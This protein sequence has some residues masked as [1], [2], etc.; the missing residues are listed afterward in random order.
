MHYVAFALLKAR[1]A[2]HICN[3]LLD[4]S[5]DHVF[6]SPPF[7]GALR[8]WNMYEDLLESFQNPFGQFRRFQIRLD[9]VFFFFPMSLS[10][11]APLTLSQ[12]Y[13][14]FKL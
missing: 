8:V 2:T 10:I 12:C 6:F 1:Q 14:L 11:T 4:P 7:R 9:R 13:D 3:D 5:S